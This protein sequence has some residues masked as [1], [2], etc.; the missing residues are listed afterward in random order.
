LRVRHG[1]G[2]EKKNGSKE[3]K[4]EESVE[5]R[6]RRRKSMVENPKVNEGERPRFQ[7]FS[8]ILPFFFSSLPPTQS[9]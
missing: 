3:A 7:F 4:K 8:S 9:R 1:G 6:E 5:V 2:E